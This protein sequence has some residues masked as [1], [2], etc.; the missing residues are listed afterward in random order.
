MNL[1]LIRK[2]NITKKF[3]ELSKKNID[4]HVRDILNIACNGKIKILAP[5]YNSN[6]NILKENNYNLSKIYKEGDIIE[7]I[8][9]PYIIHFMD[10]NKSWN[11][12]GIY[13]NKYWWNIDKKIILKLLMKRYNG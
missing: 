10:K 6:I 2:N 11:D 9:Q 7:A 13:I 3:T 12:L 8:N 5:K 1:N 4:F